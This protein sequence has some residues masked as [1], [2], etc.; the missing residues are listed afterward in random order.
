MKVKVYDL[1]GNAIKEIELPQQFNEE[2]RKDLIRRAFLAIMS[3]KRV[4]YG[5][6]PLS[7]FDVAWTSKRRRDYRSSYGR[8]ISRIPRKILVKRG[9]QFHWVGAVV[10]NAVGGRRAHPPKVDKI[11]YEKINKKER[12]KAIRSAIAATMLEY[13]VKKRG[14]KGKSF[15]LVGEVENLKKT[16]E[17]VELLKKLGLE[18]ELKRLEYKKIRA[19]KG[20]MRNRKYK[21]KVGPLVVISEKDASLAKAA[22]NIP[23]VDV[24][25][26][27]N[28]NVELL[29]PGGQAGRLTLWSEKAIEKLREKNLFF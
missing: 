14:H 10:P 27:E 6:N 21:R 26:V 28:L 5:P 3:H 22:S 4:P 1:N 16:K 20:K 15:V 24:V 18:E 13:F 2:I 12:R 8:G 11:Y 7:G 25:T 9:N 29:A 17:F 23:G 19:G